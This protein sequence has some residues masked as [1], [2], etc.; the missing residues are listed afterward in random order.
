MINRFVHSIFNTIYSP[1]FRILQPSSKHT[2]Q[3]HLDFPLYSD[4]LKVGCLEVQEKY[5]NTHNKFGTKLSAMTN[6]RNG[7]K[8][9]DRST[10][11]NQQTDVMW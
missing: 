3:L 4:K 6:S 2:L 7:T 9:G 8:D 10:K 11:V 5:S 1:I